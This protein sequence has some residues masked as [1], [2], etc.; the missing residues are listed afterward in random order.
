MNQDMA[1]AINA[2]LN[3]THAPCASF[4]SG[5][6]SGPCTKSGERL[7]LGE[8]VISITEMLMLICMR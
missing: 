5:V 2:M 8:S 6:S 1:H 4:F 3:N 7:G